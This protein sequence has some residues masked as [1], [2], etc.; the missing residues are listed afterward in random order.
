MGPT[1]SGKT[2]LSITLGQYFPI[3]IINVDSALIYR[4]MNI[5]TGKPDIE[6]RKE[7]PHH[8]IDIVS[9]LER[10]SAAQFRNDVLK[11][12]PEIL[13]RGRLPVLVGGTMLYFKT[14]LSGLPDIPPVSLEIRQQVESMA[15]EKGWPALHELLCE[16]DPIVAHKISASDQQRIQRALEVYYSSGRAL[17]SYWA[18][19]A[20][21]SFPY[22]VL[23]IALVPKYANRMHLHDKIAQRFEMMLSQGFLEE[24][25]FLKSNY[26]LSLNFPAIRSVGYRQAWLFLE[27]KVN[28]EAMK[29]QA[30][31][32]TRQLAKRQLTWLRQWKDLHAIDFLDTGAINRVCQLI[33]S[34][35]RRAKSNS[36]YF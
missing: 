19:C 26:E 27:G 31:S 33:L 34:F 25:E 11:L 17:S 21:E 20:V 6:S 29:S 1:A 10:Y 7:I 12:I 16:I 22:S 9:P 14:L 28:F 30:I 13:E 36:M 3:E 35:P 23:P 4:D 5:G 32:A 15:E 2:A 18:D 24:V 8:L